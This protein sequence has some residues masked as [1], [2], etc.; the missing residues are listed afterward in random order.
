[1]LP[2]GAGESSQAYGHLCKAF[3]PL[4]DLFLYPRKTMDQNE[5]AECGILEMKAPYF[6]IF[7]TLFAHPLTAGALA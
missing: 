2:K 6:E 4:R 5:W 1:M 3:R 7:C